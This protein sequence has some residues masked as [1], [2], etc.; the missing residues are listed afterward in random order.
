MSMVFAYRIFLPLLI[1]CHRTVTPLSL[2]IQPHLSF[3]ILLLSRPSPCVRKAVIYDPPKT[4]PSFVSPMPGVF[5]VSFFFSIIAHRKCAPLLL[6][7]KN[8]TNRGPQ[9]LRPS[10]Q[11]CRRKMTM[12]SRNPSQ[13]RQ[14]VIEQAELLQQVTLGRS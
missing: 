6:S 12:L 11:W 14:R 1:R 13:K 9:I 7:T 10:L 2:E 8:N 3:I 4:S 5:R